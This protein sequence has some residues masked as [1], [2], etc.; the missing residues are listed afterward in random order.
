MSE[1]IFFCRYQDCPNVGVET[2][3]CAF[4]E[5]GKKFQERAEAHRLSTIRLDHDHELHLSW[6]DD[7]GRHHL[8]L[9]LWQ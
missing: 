6:G 4:C 1:I 5:K 3:Q 7:D 9:R 8:S 2:S